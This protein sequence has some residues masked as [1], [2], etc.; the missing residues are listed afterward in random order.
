MFSSNK[1][2]SDTASFLLDHG[3]RPLTHRVAIYEYL[4]THPI[5]PTADMIYRALSPGFPTLS[6][7]TVYNTL[8]LLCEYKVLRQVLVEENEVRYDAWT[9][10]HGHF[11]CTS[12]GIV[13]DTRVPEDIAPPP[14]PEGSIVDEVHLVFRGM[15][16]TC[17]AQAAVAQN[18]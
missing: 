9:A 16:P 18:A 3:V 13:L 17:A 7:T 6:K 15:C 5:H 8:K 14:A 4:K 10:P 11:K 1:A 12:C 2:I